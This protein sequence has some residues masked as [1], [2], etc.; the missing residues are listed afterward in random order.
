MKDGVLTLDF[1][2]DERRLK[3]AFFEGEEKTLRPYEIHE[4]NWRQ[5]EDSCREI[6]SAL[7]RSNRSAKF[8][9][10][11]LN[12]LKKSGLLLFDLLL[13]SKAK[14]KLADTTAKILIFRLDDTLVHIPWELLFD[15]REFL[16]GRFATG[17]IA[18]TRQTPTARSIRA[19]VAPFR[20]LILADPRGDLQASYR[21]GMEIKSF[22]D[23][24]RDLFH[25]DF[26]SHPVDIA[27]VKKHLRDYDIVH[28]AGHAK[29][30]AQNPSESGW[31]LSDGTLTAAEIAALG[32][33][34]PMPALVFSNACQSGQTEEWKLHDSYG[35][36]IFGLANAFLLSGV[37]H[38]VGTFRDIV[39]EPSSHF[40]KPFYTSIAKGEGVGTA[41]RNSR[42]ALL[43][44][45]GEKAL[46]WA[47]YMLY[48]D[49]GRELGDTE[50][51]ATLRGERQGWKRILRGRAPI[52]GVKK[53]IR[54]S[55]LFLS[56]IG[57][58][59]L[60]FIYA[61]YSHFYSAASTQRANPP[62]LPSGQ[63]A[64]RVAS[65]TAPEIKAPLSLSMNIIGQRKE[66]NG[67]YT[68]VI[69]REGS[70]LQ[71]QDN[72]QVH[73]ETN[74]PSHVY[75]LLF[76]S[77][78]AASQLFPD[79]KIEQPGFVE[80]GRKI[81]IPDKDLWF[82]LDERRGTETVFVLASEAPMSDI[83]ELLDKMMKASESE[84]KRLSGE[85]RQQ[86]QIVER[87]VGGVAKGKTVSYPLSDG[88][89][90]QKVTEV[91]A[92]T[93]AV[94]RAISFEHR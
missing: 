27:F 83:R 24:K 42:E 40:A 50:K 2:R 1:G 71:S 26:K 94:V 80:G 89:L 29:Y 88:K 76:D 48:G 18:S 47:N 52:A 56:L 12:G 46:A 43:V 5:I 15:G 72:F 20:V 78:G 59:I 84:R 28:Y 38:Y 13:P 70:L 37:Q 73:V 86:I 51:R 19:P 31:L 65:A 53:S 55:P 67:S 22:L 6:L 16:C 21:E 66:A 82:W 7:N 68:E 34:Q 79:P 91:V 10:D 9:S 4:P 74:R 54:S 25:V 45:D 41:I 23:A 77:E 3:V 32:G 44:D 35:G 60:A 63:L 58:L 33:L 11:V 8:S 49:P 39:D 17:R 85:I 30:D 14:E 87:G 92:G 64:L 61:G 75:V 90:V 81:A 36:Q 69:V 93:G 57:V 62:T